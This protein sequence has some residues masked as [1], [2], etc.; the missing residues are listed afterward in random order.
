MALFPSF[1]GAE[2]SV[3][4]SGGGKRRLNF[5]SLI[6]KQRLNFPAAN[7]SHVDSLTQVNLMTGNLSAQ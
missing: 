4:F 6:T 7:H 5:A 2:N 1:Q 3:L